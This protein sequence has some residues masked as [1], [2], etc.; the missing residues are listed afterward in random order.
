MASKPFGSFR[1]KTCQPTS[2]FSVIFACG[3]LYCH[4][5]IFGLCRV[6]LCFAQLK[7]KY[8]ITETEGFNITFDLSKILLQ[9]SWNI[10][11]IYCIII[12][13]PCQKK[14]LVS[15]SLFFNE[16]NLLRDFRYVIDDS[17]CADALDMSLTRRDLYHIEFCCR[18]Q[19]LRF[20][21]KHINFVIAKTSSNRRLHIDK[22][23][24]YL[25][26]SA[27]AKKTSNRM[28]FFSAKLAFRRVAEISNNR[29][30]F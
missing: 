16:I 29:K 22:N 5:V 28:S 21:A 27:F 6:I 8:N 15:T 26:H 7:G 1:K 12:V 2:L 14:R 3:K 13:L 17:I 30:L 9:R 4:A 10:T 18:V 25:N 11:K 24:E 20:T 23:N 19:R